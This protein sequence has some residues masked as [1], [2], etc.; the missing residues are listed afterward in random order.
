MCN[1]APGL[2]RICRHVARASAY[3]SGSGTKGCRQGLCS[4]LSS[5]P[6]HPRFDELNPISGA[7]ASLRSE[8]ND[9][10]CSLDLVSHWL[11]CDYIRRPSAF[12]ASLDITPISAYISPSVRLSTPLPHVPITTCNALHDH[13]RSLFIVCDGHNCSATRGWT[14]SSSETRQA[15]HRPRRSARPGEACKTQGGGM[16]CHLR[17]Q[18]SFHWRIHIYRR[19]GFST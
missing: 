12:S 17:G 18:V 7:L 9:H 3:E 13:Q 10:R 6:P 5:F 8:V 4:L 19:L 2:S 15:T 16:C 11:G 14:S 1:L